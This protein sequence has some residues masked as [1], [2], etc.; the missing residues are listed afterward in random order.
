V[1]ISAIVVGT[2][3]IWSQSRGFVRTYRSASIPLPEHP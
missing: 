3:G 1:N 2:F